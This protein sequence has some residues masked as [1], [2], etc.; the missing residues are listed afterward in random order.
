[1][2]SLVPVH[3]CTMNRKEP[4]DLH[5]SQLPFM[6]HQLHHH[7]IMRRNCHLPPPQRHLPR[8]PALLLFFVS[9]S[10]RDRIGKQ[11]RREKCLENSPV[12]G[13]LGSSD[14]ADPRQKWWPSLRCGVCLLPGEE[15]GPVTF[16]R[17]GDF[18]LGFQL[19]QR[20]CSSNFQAG[21][22]FAAHGGVSSMWAGGF[23]HQS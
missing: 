9:R 2:K 20:D 10:D 7:L 5:R 1:M 4:C 8:Q 12:A 23:V 19:E 6:T 22:G 14:V 21:R 13:L 18:E 16:E 15:R 17:F 3:S 11:K